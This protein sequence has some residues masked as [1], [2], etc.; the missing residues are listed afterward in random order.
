MKAKELMTD[1]KNDMKK[2]DMEGRRRFGWLI[3]S[4]RSVCL[5]VYVMAQGNKMDQR[6]Q[7]NESDERRGGYSACRSWS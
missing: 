4:I 7:M 2:H 6:N 3:W 5:F 1:G